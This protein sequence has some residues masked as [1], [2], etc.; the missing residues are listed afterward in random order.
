MNIAQL[1]WAPYPIASQLVRPK[2]GIKRIV[3]LGD[4]ITQGSTV[5]SGS[6]LPSYSDGGVNPFFNAIM[7]SGG[8]YILLN[9]AGVAG[10]TTSQILARV[11]TDAIA[12]GPDVCT[13]LAGTNN[14][15]SGMGNAAIAAMMN[16]IKQICLTLMS[17]NILPV[18]FT[19]PPKNTAVP[20]GKLCRYFHYRLAEKYGL[21]LIDLYKLVVDPSNGQYYASYTS[22]GIH[23]NL[24]CALAIKG[25]LEGIFNNLPNIDVYPYMGVVAET[26]NTEI[27]NLIRNGNFNISSAPPQPDYWNTT[28]ATSSKTLTAASYP[29]TGNDF[30]YTVTA[31][32]AHYPLN[33]NTYTI[34]TSGMNAGDTMYLYLSIRASGIV[35]P[36]DAYD[37]VLPS[38]GGTLYYR[39][40][41][42]NNMHIALR[43]PLV[44][45]AI[46]QQV[47]TPVIGTFILNNYTLIN[48]T[49]LAAIWSP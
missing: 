13:V 29:F 1:Q 48:E 34:S 3:M 32:G 10:Q 30:S 8:K 25:T 33:S 11:S 19:P 44:L 27:T 49:Q 16:D 37:I 2:S 20:E 42:N 40:F 39:C 31:D 41:Q 21:P 17:A 6:H 4:S 47:Y 46:T 12:Y 18:L 7:G 35:T 28:A 23:P 38:S 45:G 14:I 15:S 26:T 22:D 36:V 9:N 24:A 5:Y 43:Y